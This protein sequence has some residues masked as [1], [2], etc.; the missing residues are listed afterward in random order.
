MAKTI[1]ADVYQTYLKKFWSPEKVEQAI[2]NKYWPSSDEYIAIVNYWNQQKSNKQVGDKGK[3]LVSKWLEAVKD[4]GTW[5]ANDIIKAN[6]S[7]ESNTNSNTYVWPDQTDLNKFQTDFDASWN[8]YINASKQAY[9]ITTQRQNEAYNNQQADLTT[10]YNQDITQYQWKQDQLAQQNT[11]NQEDYNTFTSQNQQDFNY[12]ITQQNKDFSTK[13]SQA[14][15]A[16][17]Q[18]GILK[19]WFAMWQIG[20]A[21]Q[22]FVWDQNN[23]RTLNQRKIDEATQMLNRANQDYSTN[24]NQLNTQKGWTS[25]AYNTN[26]SRL[27]T[28]ISNYWTD[29]SAWSNILWMQLQWQWDIAFNQWMNSYYQL[30]Q[31]QAEQKALDKAYWTTTGSRNIPYRS[32]GSYYY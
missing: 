21:T 29:R 32:W 18:R 8:A 13:L 27:N 24:V 5:V 23:F 16:Y 22:W 7:T 12:A 4:W 10:A 31:K 15:S 2:L 14:A 11:R 30:L 25:E 28:T 6:T 17:G 9:D 3:E 19:A 26:Q 1:K 20:E